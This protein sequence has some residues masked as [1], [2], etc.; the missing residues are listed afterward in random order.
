MSGRDTLRP[1][2]CLGTLLCGLAAF[3]SVADDDTEALRRA[4][5]VLL[6][7]RDAGDAPWTPQLVRAL[8][9]GLE[10]LPEGAR[11]FP[12]GPLELRLRRGSSPHGMGDGS[13]ARPEWEEGRRRFVLY[14]WDDASLADEA[15]AQYR[16]SALDAAE[17][18][19]LWR[20]RAI[21]HAVVQRWDDADGWSRKAAF[22]RLSG[23]RSATQV[24][25]TWAW[26]FSR[27]RGQTSAALDLVTFAEEALVPVEAMRADALPLDDRVA[28]QELSKSRF[29]R[30]RLQEL[31][32][33]GSLEAR[34]TCPVF[35]AWADPEEFSHHELLFTAPSGGR[36]QSLFGHLMLR[37]V[38]RRKEG[39]LAPG[40]A[41]EPVYEVAAITGHTDG[42]FAFVWKGLFGGY[43]NVFEQ[44]SLAAVRAE[45]VA[46]E[47]RTVRRFPLKLTAA[48][49]ERLLERL[50]ELERRGYFEYWFFTDNCATWAA[51][52]V[53][54]AL[55][56]KRRMQWLVP[57]VLPAAVLDAFASMGIIE[58]AGGAGES[59]FVSGR[60]RALEAE[61]RQRQAVEEIARRVPAKA[62]AWRGFLERSRRRESSSRSAA[63]ARLSALVAQTTASSPDDGELRAA[64]ERAVRATV[65]MERYAA[66]RADTQ[67]RELERAR[68]DWS[69]VPLP[70]AEELVALRRRDARREAGPELLHARMAR[71][72]TWAQ[73]YESAPRR[74]P[75]VEETRAERE[76]V[77]TRRVFL[78]LAALWGELRETHFA[79]DAL[80]SAVVKGERREVRAEP[81]LARSGRAPLSIGLGTRREE[82]GEGPVMAW[83]SAFLRERF[84][85]RRSHGMDRRI[86]LRLIDTEVHWG[87]RLPLPRLLRVDMYVIAFWTLPREPELTREALG[88]LPGEGPFGALGWGFEYRLLRRGQTID[89]MHQFRGGTLAEVW[90]SA[91]SPS[92]VLLYAGPELR[93][94][95]DLRPQGIAAGGFARATARMG[96]PRGGIDGVRASVGWSP[97]WALW[98]PGVPG[99]GHEV[100]ADLTVQ[101]MPLRTEG[102]VLGLDAG[103]WFE[104]E[105]DRRGSRHAGGLRAMVKLR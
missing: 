99:W 48:E 18:E 29:L 57:P 71:L 50:W 96:L 52:A 21:V 45:Q 11:S 13:R 12:G 62:P 15:R 34:R 59:P 70:S 36:P 85:E 28:C 23:W 26:A 94:W 35:D 88:T 49:N 24:S 17:R 32:G 16:L 91:T 67:L 95:S 92:H 63:H 19:R 43:Q 51:R 46:G 40:R 100:E 58:S 60:E 54:S 82:L 74:A 4:G 7:P 22:R 73:L 83:S 38:F 76:A 90:G 93:A 97:A 8:R 79:N 77:A 27:K 78:Q 5:V 68:I 33:A 72:L 65:Q 53:E 44:T 3:G 75:T 56:E 1:L 2:V 86:E 39:A 64:V 80:R 25:N 101:L 66:E 41:H 81:A 103:L 102:L 31:G 20:R 6:S 61:E 37:P 47:Q 69:G 10:A 105:S 104:L 89:A 30:E 9:E 98:R 87:I 84:G 55:D 42:P 14:G